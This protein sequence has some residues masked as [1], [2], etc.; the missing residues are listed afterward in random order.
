MANDRNCIQEM[1]V[2]EQAN[3]EKHSL[4]EKVNQWE[5]KS[6]E[7]VIQ[8]A[9]ETRQTLTQLLRES[10]HSTEIQLAKSTEQSLDIVNHENSSSS[11]INKISVLNPNCNFS[12]LY[13]S[14][15]L[16]LSLFYFST[17]KCA[18]HNHSIEWSMV[19]K[20]NNCSWWKWRR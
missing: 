15:R 3:M 12:K 2:K 5:K 16:I 8:T 6:M 10:F 17:T 19:T 11:F 4:F 9:N 13:L 20:W 18:N 14:Q 7:M 1:L